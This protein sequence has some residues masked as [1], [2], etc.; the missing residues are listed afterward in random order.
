MEAVFAGNMAEN[1]AL[2]FESSLANVAGIGAI[3][4]LFVQI[5]LLRR[6]LLTFQF[7]GT[8]VSSS[9]VLYFPL[10]EIC[11]TGRNIFRFSA[12]GRVVQTSVAS[13]LSI[14]RRSKQDSL[15]N[16]RRFVRGF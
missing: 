1:L 4:E 3:V 6:I 7:F 12:I 8:I 5:V 11:I 13:A 10:F 2:L 15:Q 14:F 9:L 16:A